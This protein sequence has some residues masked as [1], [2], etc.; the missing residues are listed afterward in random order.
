MKKISVFLGLIF[1]ASIVFAAA[2]DLI[3]P[4]AVPSSFRSTV[5]KQLNVLANKQ[6]TD[7]T[8]AAYGTDGVFA[9]R[10]AKVH[11]DCGTGAGCSLGA[12][13]LGV[14]LPAKALIVRSYIY[15]KTQFVD[16]GTC[17]V[18]L[19]CEDANNIKTATDISGTAAG[20]FIEGASTGA[21]TAFVAS[22]AAACVITATVADGGSCVPSAGYLDAYV[23]Y[24]TTD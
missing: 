1:T 18:A 10:V 12:H 2:G 11:L 4:N 20:G 5:I 17:T 8:S 7:V 16:T 19:S 14:S 24:V 22:I 3:N 13:T 6:G 23:E 15:I 9:K 21:S